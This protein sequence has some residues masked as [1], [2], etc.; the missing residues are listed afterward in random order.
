MDINRKS[1]DFSTRYEVE[2]GICSRCMKIP[3]SV[4]AREV[5]LGVPADER[6]HYACALKARIHEIVEE[7]QVPVFA[8]VADCGGD[9]ISLCARCLQD[10]LL[11]MQ[12]LEAMGLIN[13]PD[14]VPDQEKHRYEYA[15]KLGP[16]SRYGMRGTRH[17]RYLAVGLQTRYEYVR[18]KSTEKSGGSWRYVLV[19]LEGD[20]E[21]HSHGANTNTY[22]RH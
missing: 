10:I 1:E 7:C 13:E 17:L 14:D 4:A 21:P 6:R 19:K 9:E 18:I 20:R 12:A 22:T 5:C 16:W 15:G 3:Y 11:E 8:F 2:Y